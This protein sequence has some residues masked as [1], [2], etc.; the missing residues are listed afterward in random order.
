MPWQILTLADLQT[1]LAGKTEAQPWWTADQARRAIN[2]GLRVWN[3][4]TGMWTAPTTVT[5]IPDDP[6]LR[7]S[8]TLVKATRV[9]IAG[10]RL[11]PTSLRGLDLAVPGWETATTAT[12]GIHP[13][14]VVY[15]AP[16]GL[17]EIMLYPAD[18][19]PGQTDV[20]VDGVRNTPILA[21]SGDYLDMGSDEV[22]T[23][24]G[25]ALHV[26]SFTKGIEA[27]QATLP[28]RTAFFAAAAKRNAV[29]AAS[30]LY[31]QITGA[32]RLRFARPIEQAPSPAV[33]TF[34]ES[35]A[36]AGGSGGAG[37]PGRA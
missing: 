1:R 26:L 29:F 27:V 22:S 11:E 3:A 23:L 25:Y 12:G 14:Q 10:R 9:S 17:T 28:L 16:I 2:E 24:L 8:G 7:V 20:V 31:K 34:L 5:T 35:G 30:N 37:N 13:N 18:A 6:H 15:W 19:A 36:R 4:I 32:D 33:A 21:V